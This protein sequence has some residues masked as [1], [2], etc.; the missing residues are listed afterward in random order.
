MAR[1]DWMFDDGRRTAATERIYRMATELISRDGFDTFSVDALAA[2][3]HCSRATVYRYVGGKKTIREAV[4]ARAAARIVD[5]VRDAVAPLT[6]PQRVLT[7]IEVALAEIRS[8]PAGQLF[9]DTAHESAWVTQSPTVAKL[10]VELNGLAGEDAPAAQWIARVVMSLLV[11]PA[12]DV[13]AQRV[14]LER[15]VAPAF[16]AK[17]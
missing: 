12:E 13:R 2:A 4:L 3:T 14:I 7:A 9:I 8:D 5:A 6:G 16:T 1:D 17:D 15:F 11:W 10:A